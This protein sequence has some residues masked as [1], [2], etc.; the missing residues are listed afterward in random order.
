MIHSSKWY[1]KQYKKYTELYTKVH[2]VYGKNMAK[3]YSFDFFEREYKARSILGEKTSLAQEARGAVYTT[4]KQGS[5]ISERF[6][7]GIRLARAKEARGEILTALEQKLADTNIS[8]INVK[9]IRAHK[10]AA[11]EILDMLD[12]DDA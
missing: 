2:K 12:D 3:K 6:K 8:D 7:E 5:N 9:D 11:K 10:G 1:M 4:R